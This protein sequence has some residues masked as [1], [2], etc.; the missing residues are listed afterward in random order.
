MMTCQHTLAVCYLCLL[1]SVKDLPTYVNGEGPLHHQSWRS[2]DQSLRSPS[3]T[4]GS[5]IL[6]AG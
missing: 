4:V 3:P 1:I 6:G 5:R 2:T